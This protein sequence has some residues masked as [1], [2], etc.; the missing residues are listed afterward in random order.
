ERGGLHLGDHPGGGQGARRSAAPRAALPAARPSDRAPLPRGALPQGLRLP[1][2]LIGREKGYG[3]CPGGGRPD[4]PDVLVDCACGVDE[5][6]S[7][8]GGRSMP[9]I[10]AL[11]LRYP[12]RHALANGWDM[13]EG[14]LALPAEA[15]PPGASVVLDG[16]VGEVGFLLGGCVVAGSGGS[17]A[18]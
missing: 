14:T 7:T 2:R 17:R 18:L 6:V 1:A 16:R 9:P 12:D 15:P 13:V 4:F 8:S 10:V 5:S 3:A 11:A